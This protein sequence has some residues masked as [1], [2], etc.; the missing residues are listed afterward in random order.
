[1]IGGVSGMCNVLFS[2]MMFFWWMC[3][4]LGCFDEIVDLCD[5]EGDVV[6]EYGCCFFW[7]FVILCG[8]FDYVVFCL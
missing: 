8:V 5:I 2:F 3:V 7:F 4:V 1:M 6:C